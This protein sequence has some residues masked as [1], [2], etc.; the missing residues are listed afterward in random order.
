[1]LGIQVALRAVYFQNDKGDC[2]KPPKITTWKLGF[3]QT[4]EKLHVNLSFD[5]HSLPHMR[6]RRA[7]QTDPGPL[8]VPQI[9]LKRIW[10]CLWKWT[11]FC[12][13]EV[14]FSSRIIK[15]N[16]N[17]CCSISS[18]SFLYPEHLSFSVLWKSEPTISSRKPSLTPFCPAL[19]M[20]KYLQEH[21]F[22]SS[23]L[24]L[25]MHIR[26]QGRD[27]QTGEQGTTVRSVQPTSAMTEYENSDLTRIQTVGVLS[28]IFPFSKKFSFLKKRGQLHKTS[29]TGHQFVTSAWD[30]LFLPARLFC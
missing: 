9:P 1:M 13:E 25:G 18:H 12:K 30:N 24:T 27:G 29:T 20:V 26:G 19:A 16:K 7:A 15:H 2:T 3:F 5:P 17:T 11:L 28:K 23:P 21:S 8:C 6:C 22:P 10:G 14:C 4:W